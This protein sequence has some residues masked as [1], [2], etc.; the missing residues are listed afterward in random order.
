[1]REKLQAARQIV[2]LAQVPDST[3]GSDSRRQRK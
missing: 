2:D 3:G 1:L